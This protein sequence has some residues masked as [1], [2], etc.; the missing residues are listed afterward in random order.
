MNTLLLLGA[1]SCLSSASFLDVSTIYTKEFTYVIPQ[2]QMKLWLDG[3]GYKETVSYSVDE[4]RLIETLAKELID[5]VNGA[6]QERLAIIT[7]GAPG[8][9]KSTLTEQIL[10]KSMVVIDPSHQLK[11]IYYKLIT[12]GKLNP[13]VLLEQHGKE[14][15][16]IKWRPASNYVAHLGLAHAIKNGKAFYF[17]SCS[18]GAETPKFYEFLKRE[19]YTV[20]VVHVSSPKSVRLASITERNKLFYQSLPWDVAKKAAE[21]VNRIADT[22]LSKADKVSFYWRGGI[23]SNAGLASE[24]SKKEGTMK[25]AESDAYSQIKKQH[26][27]SWPEGILEQRIGSEKIK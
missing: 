2:A 20:E 9:G 16:L 5:R 8:A 13:E 14:A 11:M 7:A 22:F 6:K 25:I 26:G 4:K 15:Q 1:V 18:A 10:D 21:V 27:K 23:T 24:W 12:S 19:G 3:G 17:G